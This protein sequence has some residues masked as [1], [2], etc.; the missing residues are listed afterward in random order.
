LDVQLPVTGTH[1]ILV[2]PNGTS[3]G[4]MTL[5]LSEPITGTITVDG[6]SATVNIT[7]IGQTAR[8][9]FSGTAG[10]KVSLAVTSDTFAGNVGLTIFNPD[11]SSL[12]SWCCGD[13]GTNLNMTLSQSGI[14]TILMD[15]GGTDIGSMTFLLSEEIDAGS[16]TINGASTTVTTTRAGQRAR[17]TFSG[18]A[19]QKITLAATSD[20]FAGNV[21]LTIFNPDGSSLTSW[22]CGDTGTNLNMTLPQSGIHTIL[23][24]PGGNDTG[25]MM[26]LLSEE[27]DAGSITINGTSV[28]ITIGRIGQRARLT[29]SVTASQQATVRL[30]GN[31]MG[32]VT[33]SLL[34]PDSTQLTA[35]TSSASSF[36]LTTQTLATPGIYTILVDPSGL[37]TGSMDVSVTSP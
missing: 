10:Q 16:I 19:G 21:G 2:D 31:S 15:P 20:T 33:V 23:M 28:H 8:I 7:Q 9:N 36:N 13:T 4:S 29:F 5:T 25:S 6:P 14:H 3:T 34:R 37:N 26:F 18:T 24:D 35:S 11:G 1:T 32:L 30:T 27:I 17:L 12:T 22:C